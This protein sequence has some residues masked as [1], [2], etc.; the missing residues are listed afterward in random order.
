MSPLEQ[1][2]KGA[3]RAWDYLTEG[4]HHLWQ[5]AS[6]ALTRFTPISRRGEL[7]TGEDRIMEKSSRWGLLAA[8]VEEDDHNIT[9]R[10]E[11]PGMESSDFDIEV[12]GHT[13]IVRGEKRVEREQ[14]EGRYYIME[15]A[16]GR[17]ERA[18]PL[19]AEVNEKEAQAKYRRGVLWISLP[20]IQA[21]HRIKIEAG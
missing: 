12:I 10:L 21:K 11:V 18:L 16:Y 2:N 8:E 13:L 15:R 17:F 20:K 5:R 7:Q 9:V 1:L 14:S 19:P 4:W 6:Q 3:S